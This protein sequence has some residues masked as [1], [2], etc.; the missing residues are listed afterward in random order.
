MAYINADIPAEEQVPIQFEKALRRY[1]ENGN[2]LFRILRKCL[3]GSP[4]A[5][6]RFT[7]MRDAWMLKH[8]NTNGWSCKQTMNDKSLFNLGICA[9]LTGN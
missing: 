4:T 8:F 7:Q 3:Y 1:D 2:E 9:H 6:R 5:T